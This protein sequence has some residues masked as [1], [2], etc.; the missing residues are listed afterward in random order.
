M[1]PSFYQCHGLDP[2]EMWL[3]SGLTPKKLPSGLEEVEQSRGCRKDLTSWRQVGRPSVQPVARHLLPSSPGCCLMSTRCFLFLPPGLKLRPWMGCSIV[4]SQLQLIHKQKKMQSLCLDKISPSEAP[5]TLY[6][7]QK[8]QT[9]V[10][11]SFL[12]MCES[13]PGDSGLEVD[14]GFKRALGAFETTH[15]KDL[16]Y[17]LLS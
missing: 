13:F 11:G 5:P 3:A 16:Y 8:D 12:C 14:S 1:L 10:W 6:Q 15:L 17:S 7:P 9:S 2:R 4:P